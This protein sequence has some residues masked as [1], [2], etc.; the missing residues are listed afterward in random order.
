MTSSA[1]GAAKAVINALQSAL[2]AEQAACYG[3]G[4]LG[5]HL[6]GPRQVAARSNW[7][8]HERARDRLAAMITAKG[9]DPAPAAVAYQLPG[10][11]QT[12]AEAIAL[13]ATLE[14]RVA[15]AYLALVAL[16]GA[17]V[18]LFG[19]DQVRV[20]A[21]RAEAWRGTTQAFPGLDAASLRPGS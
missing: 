14:D 10:P 21:L 18:R 4:V 9:G 11:V 13:A 5:A 20:A 17:D 7:V 12:P 8:A 6:A 15:Q 2:A 1:S 19:A 16:P 3:Y